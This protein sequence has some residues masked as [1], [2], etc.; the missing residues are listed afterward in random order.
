MKRVSS[1]VR[2]AR[3]EESLPLALQA[4][5]RSSFRE[6]RALHRFSRLTCDQIRATVSTMAFSCYIYE[7]LTEQSEALRL[8]RV[9]DMELNWPDF[10]GTARAS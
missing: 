5:L 2:A 6:L 9:L 8:I 1:I 10:Q 4:S 7:E 3:T